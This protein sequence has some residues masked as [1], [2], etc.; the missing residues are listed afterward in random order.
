MTQV[1]FYTLGEEGL[2]ARILFACRLTDKA[3]KLGHRV[4]IQ[5]QSAAQAKWVDD[6][7]WQ[8][9]AT[10][11]VP[12]CL[13]DEKTGNESILI[14]PKLPAGSHHDVLINL[15]ARTHTSHLDFARVN[16][17]VSADQDSLEQGRVRYRFY[18]D[19]GHSPETHKI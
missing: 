19:Q 17:I 14:S 13:L 6:M 1:S 3:W 8:Y 5:T 15:S 4:F 9:Q 12:H 2:D 16:E 18:K 11:F 10:S 7:L